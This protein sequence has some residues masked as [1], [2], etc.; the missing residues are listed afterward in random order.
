MSKKVLNSA[1]AICFMIFISGCQIGAPRPRTGS[2]ASSTHGIAFLNPDKLGEHNYSFGPFEKNGIVYTCKGGHID[3]A[4]LRWNADYTKYL[5]EKTR[6]TLLKKK[7]GFSFNLT[8]E[9][10]FHKVSFDYPDYWDSLRQ[11]EREEIANKIAFEVGPYLAFNAT[12]WHEI[13]T[14]FGVHFIGFEPEFNSAFSW[15]DVYSNLLGTEIAIKALN[16]PEHNYD[17][18]MAIAID[19][20]LKELGVQ[21]KEV[22]I[23]AA[24]QMKGKWYKTS[25][26]VT[27]KKRNIDIGLDDGYVTP[28]LSPGICESAEP[29]LRPVPN[30]D[31]L[32][33]YKFTMKYEIQPNE[34]EKGKMLKVA[35]QNKKGKT[36]QPSEHYPNLIDHIKKEAVEKYG[37]DI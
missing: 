14:W 36:I 25:L 17:K 15:E 11:E 7:K 26:I 9:I 30:L 3:I 6:E 18:A 23:Q 32:A 4:H 5:V 31:I 8:W 34:F 28:V 35:H 10:S 24:S 13:L 20:E 27:M 33:E 22:A 19:K 37:Y 1:A 12:T 29:E 16:D 2:L 21:P